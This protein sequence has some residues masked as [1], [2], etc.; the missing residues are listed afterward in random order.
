MLRCLSK[1][2]VVQRL[3]RI[4]LSA[5]PSWL[6][7]CVSKESRYKHSLGVGK[8]SLLICDGT[9]HDQILLTAA[10]VLHDVGNGPF[11]HI[12]D[13]LMEDMLGFKHEGAVTFA[14]ESSP[15]KDSLI[16]Q[17]YSLDLSEVASVVKGEHRLSPLLNG[18]PDL[19]N[20]DNIHR[21]MNT[22]P[23]RPLGKASYQPSEIA[24]SMSLETERPKISGD[25]TTRWLRDREKI[26][27]YL[28]NDRLNM[29]AW[30][31][32]G[33]AIRVLR[34]E[35]TTKF[36]TMTN[37]EAFHLIQLKA[38]KLAKGLKNM[39]YKILF[40]RRYSLLKGEAQKLSDPKN[41]AKVEEEICREAGLEEWSIG[42]TVD[43]P[44]AKQKDDHWRV[45]LAAHSDSEK[46]KI[47]LEDILSSS[48]SIH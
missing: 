11:P 42:L 46:P 24:I 15:V 25:L 44:R 7:P 29:I 22:I 3:K 28:W 18:Y 20:A 37:R 39:E 19:D 4:D 40:D 48:E 38:P 43:R 9:K 16:L 27:R 34:D 30:T 12:S 23:G 33:R 45:Y 31:M 47:F 17:E 13:H 6:G 41:L 35:L 8:L 2:W 36:L 14:F 5:V 10:A 21:F 1:T 26:Y 32:L